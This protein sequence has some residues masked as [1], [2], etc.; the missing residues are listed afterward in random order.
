MQLT[1]LRV[2]LILKSSLRY[3]FCP[4]YHA[5]YD[6]NCWDRTLKSHD[7]CNNKWI[8]LVMLSLSHLCITYATKLVIVIM[9]RVVSSDG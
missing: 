2:R 7:R 9:L 1:S 5:I 8:I 4:Y 3:D 6:T